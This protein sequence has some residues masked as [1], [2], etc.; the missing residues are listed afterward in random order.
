[1]P[2]EAKAVEI[3]KIKSFLEDSSIVIST[4]Y[5]GLNVSDINL[6]RKMLRDS[7]V[8]YRV[9]KNTL[10]I[11]VAE[12]IDRPEIKNLADGP[13]GI[14]FGY[15]D[16][17]IPAK[18]LSEFKKISASDLKIRFGI[19]GDQLLTSDQIDELASLPSKEELVSKLVGQLYGQMSGLVYALNRPIS[20]LVWALQFHL[21]R[22]NSKG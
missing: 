6:L 17:Q 9:I 7:G 11:K 10:L 22:E 18:I 4:D 16:T 19:M 2:T 12:D 15:G 21:E 3:E 8:K 14:V 1:M 13:T 5:S 20:G